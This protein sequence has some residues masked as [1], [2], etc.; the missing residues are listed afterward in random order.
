VGAVVV[1]A[2]L[3]AAQRADVDAGVTSPQDVAAP[4]TPLA[5]PENERGESGQHQGGA[6]DEADAPTDGRGEPAPPPSWPAE[7]QTTLPPGTA[8][9]VALT[10]DDGPHPEWTPQLL[11]VLARHGASATFCVVGDQ[12]AGNEDLL[13]RIH[14]EGHRLCNHTATN[15]YGL[16]ARSPQKIR[17]EIVTLSSQISRAVPDADVAVFRAPGGRFTPDLVAA[18]TAQGLTSWAWSVDPLDWRTTETSA[19]VSSVLDAVAP[20]AVILLHDGGGDRSATVA[21]VAE[22]VPVL[23]SV[24]YDFVTLPAVP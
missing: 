8:P 23:Q 2:L 10:F 22:I 15:D 11:D 5:T 7:V 19:I 3:G 18:A 6:P 13:R 24:G 4:E 17:D 1:G 9:R 14:A 16:P 21:A 12:V 20:D